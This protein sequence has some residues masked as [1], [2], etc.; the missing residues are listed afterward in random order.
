MKIVTLK[1]PNSRCSEATGK[2][3]LKLSIVSTLPVASLS[4]LYLPCFF[5]LLFLGCHS[6]TLTVHLLSNM[7]CPRQIVFFVSLCK[8][9]KRHTSEVI[10][11]YVNLK[12][13]QYGRDYDKANYGE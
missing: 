2:V 1:K 9:S 6:V 10:W 12:G 13:R 3:L 5:F 7:S 8:K 4:L 11:G